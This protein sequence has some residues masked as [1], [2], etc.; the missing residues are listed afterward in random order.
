MT[1]NKNRTYSSD[2]GYAASNKQKEYVPKS[3]AKKASLM[4]REQERQRLIEAAKRLDAQTRGTAAEGN[5][6][7][8]MVNSRQ[9]FPEVIA[10]NRNA[11]AGNVQ[12]GSAAKAGQNEYASGKSSLLLRKQERQ[13]LIEAAKRLDAQTRGA[14]APENSGF[15]MVNSRQTFPE[16]I[17]ANRNAGAGN[18]QS[19]SAA[20]RNVR[21]V[22]DQPE[23]TW[24]SGS[25]NGVIDPRA[26]NE[27]LNSVGAGSSAPKPAPKPAE[28]PGVLQR[29]SDKSNVYKGHGGAASLFDEK[30]NNLK[31]STASDFNKA[32]GA[33]IAEV[34]GDSESIRKLTEEIKSI[35]AEGPTLTPRQKQLYN[36]SGIAEVA[37]DSEKIREQ[38][39]AIKD[40]WERPGTFSTPKER[41]KIKKG[42]KILNKPKYNEEYYNSDNKMSFIPKWRDQKKRDESFMETYEEA[43]RFL[44]QEEFD[45]NADALMAA[46][47]NRFSAMPAKTFSTV[48]NMAANCIDELPWK[49][50]EEICNWLRS[51][52]DNSELLNKS[53]RQYSQVDYDNEFVNGLTVGLSK[54]V[55]DMSSQA[56]IGGLFNIPTKMLSSIYSA[57]EIYNA[58]REKGYSV[59]E[60][61]GESG[62]MTAVNEGVS[63]AYDLVK[64]NVTNK[65]MKTVLE[66]LKN[67]TTET[68]IDWWFE[69]NGEE[70]SLSIEGIANTLAVEA[71]VEMIVKGCKEICSMI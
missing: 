51:M 15:S 39:E 7:F 19:G 31:S 41:E 44:N 66:V 42:E 38:A 32:K 28:K 52:E 29:Y 65:G 24:R 25:F 58:A 14:A 50:K 40:F 9:T 23:S 55:A 5:N 18:V 61:M 22:L 21:D 59:E 54:E 43:E 36:H 13:R 47:L 53:E 60:A 33:G 45:S 64:D 69:N 63:F 67:T 10:A 1:I 37:G 27:F 26:K 6:G 4:L 62:A 46:S 8:G 2:G 3:V 11:G 34:A 12:S 49:H 68:N 57:T 48:L 16:V 35:R 71:A 17:A 56:F 70:G 30:P 20:P